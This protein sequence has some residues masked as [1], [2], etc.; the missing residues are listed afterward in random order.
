MQCL[1]CKKETNYI[2][3]RGLCPHCYGWLRNRV[4]L[5]TED[6]TWKKLEEAGL[7][8]PPHIKRLKSFQAMEHKL[9]DAGLIKENL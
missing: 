3:A 6:V 8:L 9:K 4:K 7:C 2:F 1:Y 5:G